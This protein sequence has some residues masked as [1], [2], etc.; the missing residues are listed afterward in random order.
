[1]IDKTTI[2]V[3][4]V[5]QAPIPAKS[6]AREGDA[7]WRPPV[8]LVSAPTVEYFNVAIAAADKAMEATTNHLAQSAEAKAG[9]MSVVRKLSSGEIAALSLRAGEVKPA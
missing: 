8:M 5:V 4:W 9:V 6:E 1:M 7:P 2:P 3:G